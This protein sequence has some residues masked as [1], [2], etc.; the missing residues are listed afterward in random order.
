MHWILGMAFVFNM[1]FVWGLTMVSDPFGFDVKM[2]HVMPF[3][4]GTVTIYQLQGVL[5]IQDILDNGR[6]SLLL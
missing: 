1:L 5:P 3:T 4:D 6:Q 2:V